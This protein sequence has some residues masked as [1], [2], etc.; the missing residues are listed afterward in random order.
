[1]VAIRVGAGPLESKRVKGVVPSNERKW[2]WTTNDRYYYYPTSEREWDATGQPGSDGPQFTS[3]TKDN[4]VMTIPVTV[5]FTLKTDDASIVKFYEKYGRRYGVEF[6]SDGEWNDAWLQVLRKIVADPADATLDRIVQNYRW[7]DVWNDPKTKVEIEKKL[8][9]A[10]TSSDSLLVQTAKGSYFEGVSV[11]VGTPSPERQE[12]KDAV[13]KEQQ[14]VADA[15]SKEAEANAR[16][17]QA[18]A[19]VLVAKAQA[20]K[21]AAEIAGYPD[22]GSFLR[23]QMIEKGMNPYQPQYVWGGT[24]TP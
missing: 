13:A 10:L 21:K 12:L 16:A 24:T 9:D 18:R 22:V 8:A 6:N 23:A 5:R 3:V 17:A 2:F 15:Q 20:S 14:A 19:E 4:V 7:R 1:M 11:L